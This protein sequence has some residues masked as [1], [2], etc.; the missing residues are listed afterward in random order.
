MSRKR[1]KY[2]F[3]GYAQHEIYL[4]TT[5]NGQK[6]RRDRKRCDYYHKETGFCSK[7]WNKCVG[8]VICRKYKEK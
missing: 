6:G 2:T 4:P 8:P 1:E 3:A 7:I 5:G